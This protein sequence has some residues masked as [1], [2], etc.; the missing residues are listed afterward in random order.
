MCNA[1][2]QCFF[3]RLRHGLG[4]GLDSIFSASFFLFGSLVTATHNSMAS[5][6]L[7]IIERIHSIRIFLVSFRI[8]PVG[9]G[10]GGCRPRLLCACIVPVH[11]VNDV[12]LYCSQI[13]LVLCNFSIHFSLVVEWWCCCCHGYCRWEIV[14]V[15][16]ATANGGIGAAC[17]CV[18]VN[19]I[20]C[21]KCQTFLFGKRVPSSLLHADD[22]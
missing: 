5:R 20:K 17:S 2:S 4:F 12:I 11:R 9:W 6:T 1:T 22:T 16:M 14:A 18:R 8:G 13:I 10:Q 7:G 15:V 3:R 19:L 21:K